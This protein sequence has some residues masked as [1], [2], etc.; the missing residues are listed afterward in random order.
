MKIKCWE[1]G[2]PATVKHKIKVNRGG[3]NELEVAPHQERWRCYCEECNAIVSD[4]IK[5]I[6]EEYVRLK[7]AV[8]FENAIGII[9]GQN[10]NIYDYKEAIEAIKCYAEENPDKFD[11]ADEIVAAIILVHNR[12]H[13]K[14]QYPVGRYRVDFLLPDEFVVLEIDG[15]RHKH[16]KYTDSERDKEIKAILGFNWEII[17]I[18]TELI[19]SNAKELVKAI[20]KIF[21]YRVFGN[22]KDIYSNPSKE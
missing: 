8:M 16:K 13:C 1:C 12:V 10:L 22:H 9:E 5:G 6:K 15:D 20:R 7:K 3:F 21:E 4:R 17:R 18:D 14:P 11:S 2:K 19:R